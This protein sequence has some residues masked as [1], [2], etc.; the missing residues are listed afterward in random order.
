[1]RCKANALS[2]GTERE[3]FVQLFANAQE[4]NI[5]ISIPVTIPQTSTWT[6]TQ[7]DGTGRSYPWSLVRLA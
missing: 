5:K 6:L 7:T 2:A 1:L 4:E 3:L